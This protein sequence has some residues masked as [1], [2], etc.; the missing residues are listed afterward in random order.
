MSRDSRSLAG[1]R[2]RLLVAGLVA[3]LA[4]AACGGSSSPAAT[5][6]PGDSTGPG[7]TTGPGDTPGPTDTE[8]PGPGDGGEA[9]TAATTAL[10]ALDSYAFR[11]EINS[12]STTAG[13]TTASDMVLSGVVVNEPEKAS[14]LQQE[15]LD[16]DGNITSA[17]GIIVI[18]SDAWV[19][20]GGEESEW[21]PIPA[22]GAEGFIQAMA[23]FRPERMFG[24]YFAGIGGSFTE[25]G[26][27]SK[28]GIDSTHYRGDEEIGS[29]LGTIAGF[30]GQWTSDVWI[31]KDG[32]FLVHSEAGAQAAAGAEAGSFL[33]LVDITDPNSAG[34]IEPPA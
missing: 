15:Q 23:G 10:D 24:M 22:S 1:Q 2:R 20:S 16:A 14:L 18:G 34:P 9:F 5:T 19:R 28:N 26:S 31:A 25:V 21:S 30:Q 8:G 11:V 3:V 33:I 12:T 27:E 6:G 32:G 13:V 29:I 7:A 4:L 17:T